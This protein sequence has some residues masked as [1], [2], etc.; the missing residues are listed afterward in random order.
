MV[1]DAIQEALLTSTT[2][3]L[4][5][6]WAARDAY[7]DVLLDPSPGGREGFL[8]VHAPRTLNAEERARVW[9]MLEASH[10]AMLMYTSCGW[11]FSDISGIEPRQ[12]LAYA[13]R[14]IE[15]ASP[16][17]SV[18]IEPRLIEHLRE[19]RSNVPRW[20]D[21]EKIY[22]AVLRR[23]L[24]PEVTAARAAFEM[25]FFGRPVERRIHNFR[26]TGRIE[27]P[28]L[29]TLRSKAVHASSSWSGELSLADD[30]LERTWEWKVDIRAGKDG[31]REITLDAAG[32]GVAKGDRTV[33]P[34]RGMLRRLPADLRRETGRELQETLLRE[35]RGWIEQLHDLPK[36]LLPELSAEVS[37]FFRAL[38]QTVR[39]WELTELTA[40]LL[41]EGAIPSD[42]WEKLKVVLKPGQRQRLRLPLERLGIGLASRIERCLAHAA[43]AKKAQALILINEACDLLDRADRVGLNVPR[44]RLEERA[45]ELLMQS[46]TLEAGGAMA[47]ARDGFDPSLLDGPAVRRLAS[48][49]NLELDAI[50]TPA[51]RTA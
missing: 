49:A 34:I 3:C 25:V 47:A 37:P 28:L 12:N 29:D 16:Y 14:A 6:P 50:H 18:P 38:E 33:I 11:F 39:R 32:D 1:R 42:W 44:R 21:G 35:T 24:S 19:A 2:D 26:V 9:S 4:R 40:Q 7:V 46:R 5:D 27:R 51:T 30:S 41:R 23:R 15:L 20:G 10:Q 45:Y 22:R 43:G 8:A 13:A 31:G 17:L 48:H 36:R